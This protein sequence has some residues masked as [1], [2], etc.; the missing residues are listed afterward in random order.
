MHI[1]TLWFESHRTNIIVSDTALTQ[2]FSILTLPFL[3]PGEC[4]PLGHFAAHEKHDFVS[5]LGSLDQIHL[6]CR[7]LNALLKKENI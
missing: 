4:V 1:Y 2:A 6:S 5:V 3:I 7:Q